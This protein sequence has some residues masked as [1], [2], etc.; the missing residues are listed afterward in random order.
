[1][2]D[3]FLRSRGLGAALVPPLSL[4]LDSPRFTS[5]PQNE[6]LLDHLIAES[7]DLP[8]GEIRRA[9]RLM[10]RIRPLDLTKYNISGDLPPI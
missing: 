10:A 4:V 6:G 5:T 9:E 8:D 2:E 3:G 1:M 7:G